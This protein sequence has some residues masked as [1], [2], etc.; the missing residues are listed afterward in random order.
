[1]K[2]T[3]IVSAA[4]P[5]MQLFEDAICLVFLASHDQFPKFADKLDDPDK[6]VD[7]VRKTWVKM[8]PEGQAVVASDLL[9]TLP[10]ELQDLIARALGA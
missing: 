6:M 1:M 3:L 9:P 10:Q 2:I 5:E 8:T 4:D 7:I